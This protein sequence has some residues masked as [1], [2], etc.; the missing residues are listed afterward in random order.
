M[1]RAQIAV[2]R[3]QPEDTRTAIAI[4][5]LEDDVFVLGFECFDRV[6]IAG[7]GRGRGELREIQH[8]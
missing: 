8:Q 1:Q 5:R 7:D 6:Q 2:I 4:Q 3:I